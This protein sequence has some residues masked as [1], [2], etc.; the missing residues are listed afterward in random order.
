MT[1]SPNE[2]SRYAGNVS[3]IKTLHQRLMKR[4][5]VKRKETWTLVAVDGERKVLFEAHESEAGAS[6]DP[7]ERRLLTV[8]E[9]LRGPRRIARK[10]WLAL[11]D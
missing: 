10:I 8:G 9:T 11:E 5:G 6:G 7:V 3:R 1:K 2:G 4:N